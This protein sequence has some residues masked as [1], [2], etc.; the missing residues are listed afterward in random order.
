MKT[1]YQ[2]KMRARRSHFIVQTSFSPIA[3]VPILA[4]VQMNDLACVKKHSTYIG[5][6]NTLL[7]LL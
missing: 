7:A 5:Q 4:V 1:L 6:N 3:T 2:G